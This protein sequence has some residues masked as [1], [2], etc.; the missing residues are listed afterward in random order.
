[1]IQLLGNLAQNRSLLRTFV[2]RDLRARYV[3]SSLGFFWSVIYPIMNLAVYLLVFQ[4]ILKMTWGP[5]KSPQEVV[6]LMLVSIVAW[7]AFSEGISRSTSVL[8]DHQNLIQKVVFPSEV[9]PAFVVSSAMINM[10]VALPIVIGVL[11]YAM[12]NPSEDPAV[13][14]AAAASGHRGVQIGAQLLWVPVLLVLQTIFTVGLGYFF[15]TFNLYWRDTFHVM[16][17]ALTVWMFITPI[18]YPAQR[19]IDQGYSWM[20]E[21][22][23]MH[24][25][26]EMYRDV[27]AA[28]QAPDPELLVRFAIASVAALFLGATFFDRQRSRFPDLL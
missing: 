28:N 22:N 27:F 3:G 9:L 11:F 1:M 26:M 19:M 25:L 12:L 23:P 21:I 7:T 16:G 4:V 5:D 20:L 10:V 13:I 8:V 15:A 17:V 2:A 6:L 24:W 14:A 18:F